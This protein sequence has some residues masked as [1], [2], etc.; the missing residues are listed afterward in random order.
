MTSTVGT[1]RGIA[2]IREGSTSLATRIDRFG[3]TDGEHAIHLEWVGTPSAGAHTYKASY[4]R[5]GTGSHTWGAATTSPSFILVEDI[6][7]A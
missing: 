5:T 7:P 1:D 6:G 3:G 4:E 2:H